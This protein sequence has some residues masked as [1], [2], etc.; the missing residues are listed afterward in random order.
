VNHNVDH[1]ISLYAAT[2][3]SN[4]LLAYSYSHIFNIPVT[5]LR[6][7][8]VYGPWGRPDMAMYLF[9][10]AI[11]EEQ[12]LK[13]YNYGNMKRDFTYIS[14]IITSIAR[15]LDKAP[16]GGSGSFEYDPSFVTAPYRLLNIGGSH[17]IDLNYF[18]FLIESE[19]GK[20]AK[21]EFLP[22]QP[23]D[24]PETFAD[25]SELI[26]LIGFSPKISIEEGVKLYVAWY[27]E[28]YLNSPK[29]EM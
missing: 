19:L 1:P 16:S 7:F 2:K 21:K 4:E 29:H 26:K 13:V 23:G 12:T 11:S 9:T 15:L 22:I 20:S 5:G 17:P 18:I 24:V 25:I 14:D 8:T 3:K 10:K 6:F 28:Y 27:K